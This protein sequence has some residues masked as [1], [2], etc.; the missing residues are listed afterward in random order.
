MLMTKDDFR[1]LV[2]SIDVSTA[3]GQEQVAT[4]LAMSGEFASVA[5]YLR[6]NNVSLSEAAQKSAETLGA[7]DRLSAPQQVTADQVTAVATNVAQSN[8]LLTGIT[9][10]VQAGASATVSALS[11][12]ANGVQA[13]AGAATSAAQ[14]AAGAASAATDTAKATNNVASGLALAG[15][16]PNYSYRLAGDMGA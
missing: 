9:A 12:L 3:K 6:Q 2:E 15:S 5:D 10:A 8:T 7:V 11:G 16:A 13:I 1:Q 14:A 4:L